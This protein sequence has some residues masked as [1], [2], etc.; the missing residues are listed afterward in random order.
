MTIP[1]RLWIEVNSC[2]TTISLKATKPWPKGV[3]FS[4]NEFATPA[5]LFFHSWNDEWTQIWTRTRMAPR[6]YEI[7]I[8]L[9]IQ[10]K[11]LH[12]VCRVSWLFTIFWVDLQ[13]LLTTREILF[14]YFVCN[15]CIRVERILG[16][17]VIA[18]YNAE[19]EK[20]SDWEATKLDEQLN[21]TYF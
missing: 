14:K 15:D 17:A 6:C 10:I 8:C 21:Q 5:S 16:A 19:L 4:F 11:G 18:E 13:L 20:L 9:V 12:T 1:W 7:G 2:L 3:L